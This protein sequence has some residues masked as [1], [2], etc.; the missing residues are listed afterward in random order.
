MKIA[1]VRKRSQRI[2]ALSGKHCEQCG[3][4]GNLQRHHPSYE[5][6]S[7]I[8]LCQTCHAK[9]HVELGTWGRGP[10]QTKHCAIC[11]REFVP[12][13]S[14]NHKTCSRECLSEIGRR[15]AAK[16]W[17]GSSQT[18]PESRPESSIGSTDC[19]HSETR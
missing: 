7:F 16:R 13:H 15:N 8:V 10:R 1:T 5:S 11:G 4:T 14:K 18:S 9:L 2:D 17:G 6:E 19:E 3:A 12:H